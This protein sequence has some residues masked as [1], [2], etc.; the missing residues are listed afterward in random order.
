MVISSDTQIS[1]Q[2]LLFAAA[3]EV[4]GLPSIELH[5]PPGATISQLRQV[6]LEY[7]PALVKLAAISRWAVETEFVNDDYGLLEPATVAMIPPVSGG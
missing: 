7:Y 4:V 3:R 2:I 5:V 6:L 1:I